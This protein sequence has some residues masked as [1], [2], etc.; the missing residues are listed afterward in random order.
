MSELDPEREL[1]LL[2]IAKEKKQ[3]ESTMRI[4]DLK[5]ELEA[6]KA[7]TALRSMR[8]KEE[9]RRLES[10]IKETKQKKGM[11]TSKCKSPAFSILF[12]FIVYCS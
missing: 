9:A 1:L 2:R 11:L 10:K 8:K 6:L 5:K 4:A 3:L 7:D 12:S